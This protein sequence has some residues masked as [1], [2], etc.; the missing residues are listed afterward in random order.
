MDRQVPD[1]EIDQ[2]ICQENNEWTRF[3]ETDEPFLA[4]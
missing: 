3:T 4:A 2:S 1:T